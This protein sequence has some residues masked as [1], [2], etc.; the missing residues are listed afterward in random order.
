MGRIPFD[1]GPC[2]LAGWLDGWMAVCPLARFCSSHRSKPFRSY[3][4]GLTQAEVCSWH[5]GIAA[6]ERCPY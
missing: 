3:P 4:D 2:W 6:R 1:I 5:T